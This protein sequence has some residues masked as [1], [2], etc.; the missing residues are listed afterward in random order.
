MNQLF[1]LLSEEEQ[2]EIMRGW[3][4]P[5]PF[6]D[7]TI[8]Y[9]QLP[10]EESNQSTK[11]GSGVSLENGS[12]NFASDG[13]SI[14]EGIWRPQVGEQHFEENDS[15]DPGIRMPNGEYIFVFP[16]PPSAEELNASRFEEETD[17][18][19][20]RDNLEGRDMSKVAYPGMNLACFNLKNASFIDT[21]LSRADFT[22]ANLEGVNFTGANLYQA[23]L[24]S[25]RIVGADFTG[26]N[27]EMAD[28]RA[29]MSNL[30]AYYSIKNTNPHPG[31]FWP[32]GS[33]DFDDEDLLSDLEA[34]HGPNPWGLNQ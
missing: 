14:T 33:V 30:F 28:M 16:P 6:F 29:A 26:A 8:I 31:C 12:N 1:D 4:R 32:N 21:D 3:E 20:Y 34:I 17:P 7:Q 27:L 9:S 5:Q 13:L 18:Y 10:N 2:D 15:E 11:N 23:K 22:G 19:F 24:Q 25:A